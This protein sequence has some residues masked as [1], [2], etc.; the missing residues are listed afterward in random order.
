VPFVVGRVLLQDFTGVRT[1][2]LNGYTY[3][4]DMHR[5]VARSQGETEQR[6]NAVSVW[7]D[8]PVYSERERA[9]LAWTDAVTFISIDHVRDDVY[10]SARQHF[11]GKECWTRHKAP[12]PEPRSFATARRDPRHESFWRPASP[13]P[14]TVAAAASAVPTRPHGVGAAAPFA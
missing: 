11:T 3:C 6:L 4:S 8:S 2:L 5:K 14:L 10:D 7:R 1:S 9:A 12:G 13:F